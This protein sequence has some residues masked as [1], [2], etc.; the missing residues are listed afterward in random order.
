M[1]LRRKQD[2]WLENYNFIFKRRGWG[3]EEKTKRRITLM[4]NL[5]IAP[6]SSRA[7][8]TPIP[9]QRSQQYKETES[10]Q[11][12]KYKKNQ[13]VIVCEYKIYTNSIY[14]H[15]MLSDVRQH[16]SWLCIICV[17]RLFFF[18]FSYP[19]MVQNN[20]IYN[21]FR[22]NY[23]VNWPFKWFKIHYKR[24]K[25]NGKRPKGLMVF[26]FSNGLVLEMM[27]ISPDQL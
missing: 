7:N 17:S 16:Q 8:S 14:L 3:R 27:G 24:V 6:Q 1:R 10:C 13:T 12:L 11:G 19:L 2:K 21:H 23:T 26:V 4:G 5:I 22:N 20:T 9:W 25:Q 15:F 18:V